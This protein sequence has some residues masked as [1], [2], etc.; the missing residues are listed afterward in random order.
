MPLANAEEEAAAWVVRMASDQRTRADEEQFSAWL[1][2]SPDNAE[3]YADHEMI[4]TSFGGLADDDYARS[5]LQVPTDPDTGMEF[6]ET[7]DSRFALSRRTFV[8]G[9]MALAASVAA[10]VILPGLIG[11][12]V[13][14]I[15]TRPGEQRTL[16]L[17]DNSEIT[18]NTDSLLRVEMR[19]SERRLY[20]ERGQA[21]FRVEPDVDR[22]FRVFVGDD[23]VRALGTA[24]D[25]RRVGDTAEVILEEGKVAIFRD[26]PERHAELAADTPALAATKAAVIMEPGQRVELPP[27]RPLSVARVDVRKTQAWRFGRM[28]LDDTPL[29]AAVDDLNRYGGRQVILADPKLGVLRMSGVFHTS[30]PTAF[31]DGVTSVL[32][33]VIADESEDRIVLAPAE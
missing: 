19:D 30:K 15:E 9:G 16:T 11:S 29:Q 2:A 32:P 23:E 21:F 8:G 14:V 25:V 18:I 4:W 26:L 28:I 17:A 12:G 13:Q 6:V 27:T 3:A 33:V 20:L 24:F 5:V 1:N 22:P 10:A 31:V 7:A